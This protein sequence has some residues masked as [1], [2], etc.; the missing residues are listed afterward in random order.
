[1][2]IPGSATLADITS[3]DWSLML[4]ST[5]EAA[6]LGSGLGNVV[7]G[8]ADIDQCVRIILTTPKGSDRFRPTFGCDLWQYIDM[9]INLATAHIVRE[10]YDALTTWEPRLIVET[11]QVAPVLD[12]SSQSGAHLTITVVWQVNLGSTTGPTSTTTITV[13]QGSN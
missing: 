11:V 5:A 6:G 7:Q 13:P 1:V 12:G 9:P 3:G 4:D 2:A 8:L 10:V